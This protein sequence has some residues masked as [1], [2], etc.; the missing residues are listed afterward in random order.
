MFRLEVSP[1]MEDISH[2]ESSFL[3][4][5]QAFPLSGKLQQMLKVTDVANDKN[6]A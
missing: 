4:L 5:C 3:S 2:R 6:N 1:H